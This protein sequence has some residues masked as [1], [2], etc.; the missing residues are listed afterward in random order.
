MVSDRTGAEITNRHSAL[1]V[2]P[3]WV[4]Y[5]S[6]VIGTVSKIVPLNNRGGNLDTG[7]VSEPPASL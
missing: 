3:P 7:T 5:N 6:T 2:H 4:K 1:D